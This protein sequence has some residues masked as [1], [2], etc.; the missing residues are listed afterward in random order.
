MMRVKGGDRAAF[1]TLFE[2]YFPPVVRFITFMLRDRSRAEE[3]AQ[4]VFLSLYRSRHRYEPRTRF[5]S[6]LFRL[7]MNTT[8]TEYRS[9]KRAWGAR[10][11]NQWSWRAGSTTQPVLIEDAVGQSRSEEAALSEKEQIIRLYQALGE[12]PE[13]QRAAILLAR[14]EG[15]SYEQVAEALGVTVSAVKSLVHRATVYIRNRCREG[16]P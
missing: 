6:F 3:L 13:R 7:A 9:R 5:R 10:G 14:A 8:I 12:L 16:E 1:S 15:M 2:R 4:D 11:R